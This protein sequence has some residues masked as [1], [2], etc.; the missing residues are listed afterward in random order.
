[1]NESSASSTDTAHWTPAEWL[2]AGQQAADAGDLEHAVGA[3]RL[4]LLE[5]PGDPELHFHLAECLYRQGQTEAATERYYAAVECDHQY[6]EAWTQLGCVL[7]E[8]G[9]AE[10]ALSAFGV[11]L[12]FHPDYPDAHRHKAALLDSLGQSQ[13]ALAHWQTY[14]QYDQR[15]PWAEEARHRLENSQSN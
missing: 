8:R 10:E 12:E 2:Q 5:S 1:M 13:E 7:E 6:I 9:R 3:F 14:L 15:G 11:A 4:C